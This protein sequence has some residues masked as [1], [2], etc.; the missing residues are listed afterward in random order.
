MI[1]LLALAST[2]MAFL[3][4]A[5]SPGP[6]TISNA[7]V[8]MSYGR[9]ASLMHGVGLSIGLAF[10]G[11]IAA[12]GMGAVLQSS[13]YLLT[14]LKLLGGL[15]LLWLAYLAGRSACR[16]DHEKPVEF[17]QRRWFI[18]G[19]LLNLSNPKAVVAW[20]AALSVGV[21]SNDDITTVAIATAVCIGIGFATY[22]IYSVVFSFGGVMRAYKRLRRRIDGIVA[23]LF[24]LAGLGLIR[25]AFTR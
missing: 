11:L 9:S 25:S 15:Y 21:D 23:G 22:A 17:R 16:P 14:V 5:A 18:S 8:A 4:V 13:I 12:S 6:A 2:A 19:L 7:T 10:W 20:M 3:I 24:A 1:D